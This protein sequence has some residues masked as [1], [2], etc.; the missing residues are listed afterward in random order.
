[1][2]V[3]MCVPAWDFFCVCQVHVE[4]VPASVYTCI[5]HVCDTYLYLHQFMCMCAMW[6]Q[7][8]SD[9]WAIVTHLTW[10]LKAPF[11]C[12]SGHF[13]NIKSLIQTLHVVLD[14]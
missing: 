4:C 9:T 1:M 5:W 11:P 13:F 12:K 7:V 8:P 3:Y 2:Y 14:E 10:V 6:K